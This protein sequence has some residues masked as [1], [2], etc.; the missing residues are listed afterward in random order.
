MRGY[1]KIG[2]LAAISVLALVPFGAQAATVT[3]FGGSSSWVENDVRPGGTADI[4]DLTGAGGNL[5]NNAPLGT[6]AVKLTTDNT[7]EAKAEV[8]IGGNFGTI[9]DFLTGGSLS[10]WYFKAIGN[11]NTATA[12]SIKLSVKDYNITGSGTDDFATFVFEPYWNQ[13]PPLSPVNPPADN[14][15]SALIN[16]TTGTFWHTGIYDEG[17]QGAEGGNGKTLADWNSHFGGD[18]AD[19]V[20][21]GISVGIGTYNKGVTTYF[22]NVAFSNGSINYTADFEAPAVPVPAALPLL[23]SGLGALGFV[24][25]RKQ[26]R[27]T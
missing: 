10:Y 12:A 1:L 7:N 20:I 3:A 17:G 13:S 4:V 11:T 5:E 25:W 9:A 18:L 21:I 16:G 23:L 15:L 2:N 26:R 24:G 27:T 22:D 8:G 6:G 14:W 19:A